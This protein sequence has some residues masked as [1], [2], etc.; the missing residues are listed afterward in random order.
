MSTLRTALEGL[1]NRWA[2]GGNAVDAESCDLISACSAELLRILDEHPAG[3]HTAADEVRAERDRYREALARLADG[4]TPVLGEGLGGGAQEELH[5][6]ASL[7]DQALGRSVCG[8][9]ECQVSLGLDDG[10]VIDVAPPPG[11]LV[12]GIP[13]ED[14]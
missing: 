11:V 3:E 2:V 13:L 1:V 6:R 4:D 12:N 8:C 9:G 5:V 10:I 7:A 14:L